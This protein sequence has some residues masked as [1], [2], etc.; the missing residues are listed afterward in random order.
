[1]ELI[2]IFSL[3]IFA[4]WMFYKTRTVSYSPIFSLWAAV[5]INI[6]ILIGMV[7]NNVETGMVFYFMMISIAFM[8]LIPILSLHESITLRSF[9]ASVCLFSVY[10]LF[11]YA[12]GM[13]IPLLIQGYTDYIYHPETTMLGHQY[14]HL[15]A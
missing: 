12:T 3:W 2:Y 10:I 1:M 13:T 8:K 14:A 5:V 6:F 11:S 7:Y 9:Y 4:W 15:K